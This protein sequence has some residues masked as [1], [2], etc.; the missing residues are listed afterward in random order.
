MSE[1]RWR[2]VPLSIR[3]LVAVQAAVLTYGGMVHIFHLV[4]DG[5]P[6][7]PWAPAW[8]SVY[9]TSLTLTDPLAAALLW[10]RRASGLYLG[11]FILVTDA[12]ANGYGTYGLAVG[13]DSA[14]TAQA[15]ISL[16]ALTA[17]V[18][19]P[20]I[21]PWLRSGRVRYPSTGEWRAD[22]PDTRCRSGWLSRRRRGRRGRCRLV[23][24]E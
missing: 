1:G 2:G 9:F 23:A 24:D 15:I 12:A 13:G 18:T 3:C 21:H 17:A 10:A 8:L 7:Y 16:L 6:P 19:A 22:A 11:V 5:W 14:R 4:T 20:R